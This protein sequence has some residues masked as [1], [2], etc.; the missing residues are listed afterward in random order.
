MFASTQNDHTLSQKYDVINT[1]SII[2]ASVDLIVNFMI[3]NQD[4]GRIC[5]LFKDHYS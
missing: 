4:E 1:N 2:T 5:W 3:I